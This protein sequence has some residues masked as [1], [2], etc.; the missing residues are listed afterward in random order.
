MD[1]AN[2]LSE[3]FPATHHPVLVFTHSGIFIFSESEFCSVENKVGFSL[4]YQDQPSSYPH[5]LQILHQL[6]QNK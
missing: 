3:I 5:L 2:S 6:E 1:D 4:M